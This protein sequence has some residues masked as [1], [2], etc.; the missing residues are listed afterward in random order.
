MEVVRIDGF[1][2]DRLTRSVG[3]ERLFRRAALQ[4]GQTGVAP[5]LGVAFLGR[6]PVAAAQST[7]ASCTSGAVA[8]PDAI[9]IDGA[10]FCNQ[11]FAL[12]TTASCEA[13]QTDPTIVNSP[14]LIEHSYAI[15]CKSCAERAPTG[16][17]LYSHFSTVYVNSQFSV[18]TC[19][20][21]AQWANC[22]DVSCKIDSYNPGL[23]TCQWLLVDTGPSSTFGG[24]CDG[25]TCTSTIWSAAPE[26]SLGL[27][28]YEAGMKQADQ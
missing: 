26:G 3:L 4:T 16:N 9:E 12:C 15:G 2:F 22:L 19:P 24:S 28:Q 7:P 8:N 17:E 5:A 14:C 18:L 27:A 23:A 25:C 13:S 20:E 21:N 10:W 1:H 11:Q 6:E